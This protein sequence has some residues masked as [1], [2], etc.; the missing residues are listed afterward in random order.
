MA[1]HARKLAT[2]LFADE[3]AQIWLAPP[4]I[5]ARAFAP[6]ALDAGAASAARR[7]TVFLPS[8][9]SGQDVQD[10]GDEGSFADQDPQVSTW[11]ARTP[12]RR[13]L[14]VRSWVKTVRLRFDF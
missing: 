4:V 14:C 2:T 1:N 12:C 9:S 13:T 5:A 8:R 7:S 6:I 11:L 10:L 3:H